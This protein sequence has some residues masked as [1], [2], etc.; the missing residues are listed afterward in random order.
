[1]KRLRSRAG[2]SQHDLA[3]STKM[4][5]ATINQVEGAKRGVALSSLEKIASALDVSVHQIIQLGKEMADLD[6]IRE[7][8]TILANNVKLR[9]KELG[10]SQE[11]LSRRASISISTV[12]SIEKCSKAATVDVL[13]SVAIGLDMT[14]ADLF[15]I[16]S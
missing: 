8:R 10:L 12:T 13:Q 7:A 1:M 5:V 14:I 2:L 6:A 11:D 4:S 3:S 16:R 15:V 9:R